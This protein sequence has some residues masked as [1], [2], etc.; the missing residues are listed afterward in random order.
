MENYEIVKIYLDADQSQ[1]R[2]K[3]RTSTIPALIALERVKIARRWAGG[4]E[5]AIR[6]MGRK[7]RG[8]LEERDV[9]KNA[10]RNSK[11]LCKRI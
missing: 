7:A 8:L 1:N 11:R 5:A 6:C 9:G 2:R 3:G 4:D 10:R